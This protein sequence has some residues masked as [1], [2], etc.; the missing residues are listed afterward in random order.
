MCE[1]MDRSLGS[2]KCNTSLISYISMHKKKDFLL[3]PIFWCEDLALLFDQ[4]S[5]PRS[6]EF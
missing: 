4:I 3:L 1:S 5:Q 6:L 2:E